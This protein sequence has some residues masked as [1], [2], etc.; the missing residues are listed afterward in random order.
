MESL[1]SGESSSSW[2]QFR[3]FV[4]P[5][6]LFLSNPNNIA[7]LLT[8]TLVP[9]ILWID[10]IGKNPASSLNKMAVKDPSADFKGNV[11]VNNNPPTKEDLE[12]VADLPVL[13][14]DGKKH[15][16]KGLYADNENGPRRVLIIFIRHFFCGNCQEYLR[17]VTSSITPNSLSA[18]SPPTEIVVIGCGQPHLIPMYI[19]ETGCPFPIYADPSRKLYRLLRMTSTLSLGKSPQYMQRSVLSMAVSSFIQELK[20]GRNM[21]SGGDFRQVG[22]EFFFQSGKVTWCHRM[23]NTRDHAEIPVVRQQLGLDDTPAPQRKRWS[24]AGIGGGIT[25]RLSNRRPMSW[26]GGPRSKSGNRLERPASGMDFL[27]EEDGEKLI[28]GNAVASGHD[29][30]ANGTATDSVATNGPASADRT[31]KDVDVGGVGNE[32][33]ID[34]RAIVERINFG[35]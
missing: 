35:T 28:H 9:L 4:S 11:K 22:G 30:G 34:A 15:T 5:I 29:V 1:S 17:T 25:R 13:D 24:A 10:T 7:I 12:K 6:S 3:S 14:K 21:L 16:F 2:P 19:H 31:A 23:R 8:I 18:L 32:G 33:A 26:A 20:S 27:R